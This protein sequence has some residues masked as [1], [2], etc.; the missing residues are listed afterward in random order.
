MTM[1]GKVVVMYDVWR[2][3]RTGSGF[4][5]ENVGF[6]KKSI[7]FFDNVCYDENKPEN[8]CLVLRW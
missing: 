2:G 1:C 5:C 8:R 4:G 6:G 3:R 7:D